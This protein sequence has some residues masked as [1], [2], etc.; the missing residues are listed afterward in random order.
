MLY[1][2]RDSQPEQESPERKVLPRAVLR[3]L[4]VNG[5]SQWSEIYTH[6]EKKNNGAGITDA[7]RC[8]ALVN[9]ITIAIGGRAAIT[10]SG[11]EQLQR[12]E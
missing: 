6:F 2:S 5:P 4:S 11:A 8:L 9:S 12:L 3:Y 1:P 10:A 7:L